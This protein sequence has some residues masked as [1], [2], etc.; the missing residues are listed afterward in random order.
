M[1]FYFFITPFSLSF[2]FCVH[3]ASPHSPARHTL[4]FPPLSLRWFPL[5]YCP[6]ISFSGLHPLQ[7]CRE[8]L[9]LG[10][11]SERWAVMLLLSASSNGLR[12]SVWR[13]LRDT[14][15]SL[16]RWLGIYRHTHT[17]KTPT[18]SITHT[19]VKTNKNVTFTCNKDI[20]SSCTYKM[21]V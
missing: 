21:S 19:Y 8:E 15:T 6:K 5:P 13:D 20:H 7:P 10:M 17:H 12:Y 18:H 9:T 14:L 4:F 3:T 16:R 11:R 1:L 2:V